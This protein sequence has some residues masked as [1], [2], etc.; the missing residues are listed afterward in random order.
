MAAVFETIFL[1]WWGGLL[2][3]GIEMLWRKRTNRSMFFAGGLSLAG[4]NLIADLFWERSWLLTLVFC[5]LMITLIEF[6]I[7]YVVNLKLGLNVWNY[8]DRKFNIMGQ[9]CPLYTFFW[10]ALSL[11]AVFLCRSAKKIDT[12]RKFAYNTYI[13]PGKEAV[14]CSVPS[15]FSSALR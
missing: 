2:Y 14:P 11:P 10:M 15:V 13:T 7:G 1:F 12:A 9:V 8:S 3:C 4:I 5:G 6:A